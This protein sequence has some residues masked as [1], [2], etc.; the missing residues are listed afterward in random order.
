MKK[1]ILTN[2]I[3]FIGLTNLLLGQ[4]QSLDS[5]N[6]FINNQAE[7]FHVP[8][9]AACVI[10]GDS[11]V[12]HNGYGYANI[13]DEKKMTSESILN[14]ASISKTITATAIMQLW[15]KGLLKLD[16]DVN[17][18]LDFSV[19]NP[20]FPNT[21]ITIKQLLTHT[22]SIADGSSLK[23]GYQCGDPKK[24]LKDWLFNYFDTDGEYYNEIDN[25][26]N[27]EPASFREYSNVGFG[28]LGL[29]VEEIS[30]VPFNEYVKVKIF[31]PLEM[32]NSGYFLNEVD[33]N[34]LATSYLYLGPLQENLTEPQNSKLPYY[35]PYC[36]YSFWNY[37]DGLVRTSVL[38]LAKFATAYMNGGIYKGKRILK[39]ETI[40]FM[41]SPQ[42][43][44]EINVDKDQG[45][46]WFQ[47]PSLYPTWY[48]GG[49]DPGVS[50]RMY[51]NKKDKLGVIVFQN[52]NVDN[53][54]YI[55]K[56]LYNRFK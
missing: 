51:I 34:R 3:F 20:N 41:M 17:N 49:S 11:I 18:Y 6:D 9:I 13:E 40:E 1:L 4:D 25:F 43:S 37:P 26:H 27:K 54:F 46:C 33:A 24:E 47:S 38:D 32:S 12:W 23:V 50:T 52:A 22:S 53:T 56:E 28:L 48:H 29:I 42:L 2:F 31:E 8:G 19:T 16:A 55:I 30:G 7:R 10:K 44:E 45:L 21:P 36:Q 35:N 15:E 39:K 5:L 14:I